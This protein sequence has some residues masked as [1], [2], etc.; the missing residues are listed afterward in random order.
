[1]CAVELDVGG[2]AAE[3]VRGLIEGL[4]SNGDTVEL[5]CSRTGTARI[6]KSDT[7]TIHSVPG[8]GSA[9]KKC[10]RVSMKAREIVR[11]FRPDIVYLR[12]FPA[13]YYLLGRHLF[14]IAIPY[15]CELNSVLTSEY[16]LTGGWL[17]GRLYGHLE[18]KVIAR[19]SGILP[20]TREILSYSERIS[21]ASPAFHFAINGVPSDIMNEKV[22]RETSRQ[23]LKVKE[24]ERIVAMVGFSRPWHGVDHAL[25]MLATLDRRFKLWLV[26]SNSVN[27][28]DDATV[29]LIYELGISDRVRI[30]PYVSGVELAQLLAATDVGLGALALDRKGMREA[31][32][33]KVAAYLAHG[34]PVLY[35]YIDL[36]LEGENIFAE[37]VDGHKPSTLARGAE[38][39]AFIDSKERER[40]REFAQAFSW[41]SVGRGV[42]QFMRDIVLR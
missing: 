41:D 38:R 28:G 37:Q 6:E 14:N 21:G 39:L 33:M 35:N 9:V 42:S 8:S 31:Q 20:V 12:P 1:M 30:F 29:D 13:A 3:H 5:I 23:L 36:R 22:S 7:F 27:N 16:Q 4:V 19:S 15:V 26:G 34:V 24:N 25:R 10:I 11:N 18:G 2:G 40:A 17:K 32:P